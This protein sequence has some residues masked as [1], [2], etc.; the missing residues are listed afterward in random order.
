MLKTYSSVVTAEKLD[1][2]EY[3]EWKNLVFALS[4]IHSLVIERRKYGPLGFCVPY[5]FNNS[6][7]EASILFVEKQFQRESDLPEK[8]PPH[9][10]INFKTLTN[11][12][13]SIL[14]GGRIF[15][16]KDESLFKTIVSSYLEDPAFK[17]PNYSF[18]PTPKDK[19]DPKN[20][21]EYKIPENLKE[22]TDYIAHI[23]KFPNVDPPQVFGLHGSADMT[24]RIKEFNE[25]LTT[26][27]TALPK[28]GGSGGGVSKEDEVRPKVE[29]MLDT[30][31]QFFIEIK[32]RL[33][34]Q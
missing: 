13:S 27:T 2:F 30:F 15:D 7:L 32:M 18:Y 8:K 11:V 1:I 22:I 29:A 5:D 25:L 21:M 10:M 31:P 34:Y 3:K 9:E 23:S 24:F 20:K 14:Y 33:S 16:L 17:Q 28:D 19:V 4:F 12:V 6:D 26:I